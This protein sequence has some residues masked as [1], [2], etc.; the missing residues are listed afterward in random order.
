[1]TGF[2][3]QIS[4]H[5]PSMR[6]GYWVDIFF[7]E[8]ELFS[9]HRCLFSYWYTVKVWK[10]EEDSSIGDREFLI[11]AVRDNGYSQT[12]LTIKQV[13]TEDRITCKLVGVHTA[14]IAN[15]L[16]GLGPAEHRRVMNI[17]AELIKAIEDKINASRRPN[18]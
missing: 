4:A 9:P 17:K 3:S 1:M 12:R 15:W 8:V 18:R 10:M 6:E 7:R 5:L 2:D 13:L 16:I 14:D 11:L